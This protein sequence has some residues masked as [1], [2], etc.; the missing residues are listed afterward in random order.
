MPQPERIETDEHGRQ[1]FAHNAIGMVTVTCGSNARGHLV[2]LPHEV[3][4]I[5]TVTISEAVIMVGNDGDDHFMSRRMLASFDLSEQQLR[6][7]S[8]TNKGVSV[9]VTLT[10]AAAQEA[11]LSRRAEYEPLPLLK[12]MTDMAKADQSTVIADLENALSRIAAAA[13]PGGKP[14]RKE[15]LTALKSKITGARAML[16]DQG[17]FLVD[18][19]KKGVW[20]AVEDGKAEVIRFGAKHGNEHDQFVNAIADQIEQIAPPPGRIN[21]S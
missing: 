14:L 16:L 11:K 15:D 7:F 2:G 19:V 18:C 12:K 21:P 17:D 3:T 8:S 20:Q 1:Y 9:P 4:N 13:E 5:H 6:A 10:F